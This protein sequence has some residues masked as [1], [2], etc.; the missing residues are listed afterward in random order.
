MKKIAVFCVS[1]CSDHERDLYLSTIRN[2]AQ[3]AS[4]IV[5]VDVFVSNNTKEDNPGYFGAIKRLMQQVDVNNYDYSIISNVDLMLEEDFFQK[6]ADYICSED[7]GWIAPQIWSNL[8]ERDRNP[9]VLNRYSLKKLQ[10]LRTFYQFPILDTLYTSTFYKKK[11]YESHQAGQIYAGHGSF[12]ILTR[13]FFELCGKID[14]PVFLFCEEIYLA[15]MCR[16]AGLK[17]LYEPSLIVKDTE[18]ASTGRMNHGFYC[19]CN[20]EAMQ[21]IIKTFYQQ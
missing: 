19:R 21:Y 6:L 12:I 1:Y 3:K 10:I 16:K 13:R 17:V 5:D 9:K 7:T 4:N 15:E 2:A 14:Y 18:H 20:Y 8:E 11:K